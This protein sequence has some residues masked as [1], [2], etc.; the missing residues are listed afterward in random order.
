MGRFLVLDTVKARCQSETD[1]TPRGQRWEYREEIKMDE[2]LNVPLE[3]TTWFLNDPLARLWIRNGKN[4]TVEAS[5]PKIVH[6]NN[7]QLLSDPTRALQ[8]LDKFIQDYVQGVEGTV[9]AFPYSRV[10]YCHNFQVGPENIARYI[11][12]FSRLSPLPKKTLHNDEET[13]SWRSNGR[14]IRAYNKEKELQASRNPEYESAKGILRVEVEIK[15]RSQVLNRFLK[16]RGRTSFL[17]SDAVDPDVAYQMLKRHIKRLRLDVPITSPEKALAI[18]T[19]H[20]KGPR[21]TQLY[22]FYRI[23]NDHGIG[24]AKRNHS[25]STYYHFRKQ[26][27]DVGLWLACPEAEYLP[28]LVLPEKEELLQ[29]LQSQ[30]GELH[31]KASHGPRD[32]K[33]SRGE[34]LN[35]PQMGPPRVHPSCEIGKG[36]PV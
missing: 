36:G 35:R 13:I 22:G 30:K 21:A 25:P 6:G 32:L 34:T 2:K 29:M 4:L 7:F 24:K 14:M 9:S 19:H 27:I 26:L 18:L 5:L 8:C 33:L 28:P 17:L 20:F 31:G 10:D 1:L 12:A 15:R 3:T 16:R 23:I 11:K